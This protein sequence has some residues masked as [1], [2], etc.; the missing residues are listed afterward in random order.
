MKMN[1]LITFLSLSIIILHAEKSVY[2]N[3][4]QQKF[5]AYE[6]NRVMIEGKVTTGQAGHLTPTGQFK[7]LKKTKLH[8]S[9]RYP[10]KDK[11]LNLR[12]GAKMPYAQRL[13]NTGIFIHAGT[14]VD[15]PDS[16]GCIR[17]SYDSAMRLY[18][19]TDTSTKILV[20]GKT[21]LE[22]PVN[23]M[24]LS[25]IKTNKQSSVQRTKSQK[26]TK[27]LELGAIKWVDNSLDYYNEL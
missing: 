27:M 1:R 11:K 23:Q 15:Y 22:D 4:T 25:V 5:T 7:I 24:R 17:V 21:P 18:K 8:I 14:L 16:H 12:G 26:T 2:I 10:I 3:L 20:K 6:N 19:W 13:T 9:N